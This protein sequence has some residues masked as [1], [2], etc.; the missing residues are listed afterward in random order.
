MFSGLPFMENACK[1]LDVIREGL[2]RGPPVLVERPANVLL[3]RDGGW[4]PPPTPGGRARAGDATGGLNGVMSEDD[5]LGS[6]KPTSSSRAASAAS[7]GG[8]GGTVAAAGAHVAGASS[9]QM[10]GR[11]GSTPDLRTR[12]VHGYFGYADGQ[13]PY[14][15][16]GRG[17]RSYPVPN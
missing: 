14:S 11:T 5:W 16:T 2:P 9:P 17:S 12:T 10:I 4:W 6:R 7:R 15:S 1:Q 8:R 3:R 13:L